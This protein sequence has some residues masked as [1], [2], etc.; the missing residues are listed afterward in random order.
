[1][2][3]SRAPALNRA[4]QL[5]GALV[6]VLAHREGFAAVPAGI[7]AASLNGRPNII[8]IVL[9]TF[10]ADRIGALRNGKSL[11]PFLDEWAKKGLVFRKA[12]SPADVTPQSHFAMLTGYPPDALGTQVDVPGLS[13]IAELN[14]VGYDTIGLSANPSVDPATMNCVVPFQTFV[15]SPYVTATPVT[16]EIAERMQRYRITPHENK[17]LEVC[18]GKVL[19][20][21][22]AM[23]ERLE[24][25]LQ[26]CEPG[27]RGRPVFLF[28]NFFDT[29]D[30]YMPP[31]GFGPTPDRLWK[32]WP[33]NGDIRRFPV[34]GNNPRHLRLVS[35]Y[36]YA[37]NYTA[38]ELKFL[39]E[40]YDGCVRY[41]DAQ[42]RHTF[43]LLERHGLLRNAVVVLTADHG[44]ALGESGFLAH[45]LGGFLEKP[46]EVPLVIRGYGVSVRPT[47]PVSALTRTAR[48]A[49]SL[50]IWA[51]TDDGQDPPANTFR[52]HFNLDPLARIGSTR[53]RLR[54]GIPPA[55]EGSGSPTTATP[56]VSDSTTKNGK[57]LTK[58]EKE[59]NEELARRLRSLGYIK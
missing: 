58:E 41:L 11:T 25:V 50:R 52:R 32:E 44:E 38:A 43:R 47:G 3:E 20:S 53:L 56:A 54:K 28:M 40:L 10:R 45:G 27:R 12:L 18:L 22:E 24:G 17:G 57:A 51:R 49:D 26:G 4:L 31:A 13:A 2:S 15:S 34:Q 36:M 55:S 14:A 6:L 1:M 23:N 7:P 5:A 8:L 21:A 30:S 42:L 19:S 9:D 46:F 29:H 33:V 16:A 59:R 37:D 39:I 48:L 35:P